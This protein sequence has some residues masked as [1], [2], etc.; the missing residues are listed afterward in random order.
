ML[1][2]SEIDDV[3]GCENRG[4]QYCGCVAEKDK[5]CVAGW[6]PLEKNP[7]TGCPRWKLW[8]WFE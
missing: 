7:D 4:D 8:C 5:W 2:I 1:K 3:S 6:C